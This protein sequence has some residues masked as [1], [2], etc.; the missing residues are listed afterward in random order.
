MKI[1]GIGTDLVQQ[2]R[3]NELF[4]RFGRKFVQRI[5]SETEL[6]FFDQTRQRQAYLAKRFAAKEAIAKA[7][8]VGFG[9]FLTFKEISVVNSASGKPEV[10]FLGKSKEFADK[11]NVAEVMISLSDEKDYALAFAVAVQK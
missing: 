1:I 2:S 6:A 10:I 5:L 4:L 9:Q 11:L 3:I 8:G 7:L